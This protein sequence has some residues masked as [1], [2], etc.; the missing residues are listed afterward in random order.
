MSEDKPVPLWL[1]VATPIIVL[2]S[3]GVIAY[4]TYQNRNATPYEGDT[5]QYEG[6]MYAKWNDFAD[7]GQCEDTDGGWAALGVDTST[8]FLEGCRAAIASQ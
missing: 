3:L 1:T 2:C 8:E 4:P 6:W 5:A 7:V